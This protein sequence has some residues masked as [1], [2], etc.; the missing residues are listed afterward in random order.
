MNTTQPQSI[1]QRTHRQFEGIVVRRNEQKTVRVG[2][3]TL[4]TNRKYQ[5]QYTRSSIYPVHDERGEAE[6]GD[7]ILFEECR[8]L[9]KTKRWR[10]VR[11]LAKVKPGAI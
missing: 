4:K 1:P 11:V 6:V 5:K 8:P 2:V 10:F 3:K 9:S 7:R